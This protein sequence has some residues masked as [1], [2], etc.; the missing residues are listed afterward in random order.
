MPDQPVT[1]PLTMK[2]NDSNAY[3][4]I[5]PLRQRATDSMIAVLGGISFE[6]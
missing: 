1:F 5:R 2:V 3:A 4:P 6:L